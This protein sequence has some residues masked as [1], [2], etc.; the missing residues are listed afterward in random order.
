MKVDNKRHPEAVPTVNADWWNFGG[1]TRPVTLI[2]MPS[3]YI[4]D[5]YVQLK[6]NDKNTVEG[7]VQLDGSV[8]EQKIMLDIP[9]LKVKK[10]VVTDSNGYA[11][12]RKGQTGLVDSGRT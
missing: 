5:Y 3:T 11:S 2:E 4:R 8:K 9:E 6:K 1:I 10:E 7:W 12:F